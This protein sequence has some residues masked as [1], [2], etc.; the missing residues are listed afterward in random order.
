MAKRRSPVQRRQHYNDWFASEISKSAYVGRHD[1]L[2]H[3]F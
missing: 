2:H 1:M 3:F